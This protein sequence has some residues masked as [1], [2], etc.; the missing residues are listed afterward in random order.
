MPKTVEKLSSAILLFSVVVSGIA[1]GYTVGVI[2]APKILITVGHTPATTAKSDTI[3]HTP[4]PQ[5]V[6]ES[7]DQNKYPASV[8]VVFDQ[9]EAEI[10]KQIKANVVINT[11]GQNIDGFDVVLSIDPQQWQIHQNTFSLDSEITS[12]FSEIPVNSIDPIK[13]I[14]RLSGLTGLEK[15]VKGA[16]TVG[17]LM[18]SPQQRGTVEV[19]VVF[20]GAGKPTTATRINSSTSST[21]LVGSVINGTVTVK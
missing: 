14:A 12:M 13:G 19:R 2:I 16:F 9:T 4:L 15:R 1:I 3:A 7:Y 20:D 17:Y 10:G 21:S 18:L 5:S 6:S 8:A 11:G